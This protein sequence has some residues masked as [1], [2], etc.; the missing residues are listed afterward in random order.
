MRMPAWRR[1]PAA[2]PHPMRPTTITEDVSEGPVGQNRTAV[3]CTAPAALAVLPVPDRNALQRSHQSGHRRCRCGLPVPASSDHARSGPARQRQIL[4]RRRLQLMVRHKERRRHQH[5]YHPCSGNLHRAAQS[6]YSLRPRFGKLQRKPA[7]A[8]P[9][10]RRSVPDLP[11]RCLRLPQ[12]P[13]LVCAGL[14]LHRRDLRQSHQQD[15]TA[16]HAGQSALL[17]L[18]LYPL[19]DSVGVCA[20]RPQPS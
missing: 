20:D 15:R 8:L 9:D 13:Q 12:P 18:T 19:Q 10:L 6:Q 16:I 14:H 17:L 1:S 7:K 3:A 11:L 2:L 4:R 5:L